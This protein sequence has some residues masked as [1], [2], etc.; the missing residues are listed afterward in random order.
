MATTL[1]LVVIGDR[2]PRWT[3]KVGR[4]WQRN[5]APDI[6]TAMLEHYE[7]DGWICFMGA[8]E[9]PK[10]V[11]SYL[12]DADP[13]PLQFV[14][15]SSGVR[16]AGP[17]DAGLP[18]T[19]WFEKMIGRWPGEIPYSPGS[20]FVIPAAYIRGRTREEIAEARSLRSTHSRGAE[21]MERLWRVWL[22]W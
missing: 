7:D 5:T 10:E 2:L 1:R 15:I 16:A 12:H 22:V 21:I 13:L 14:P 19:G 18:L 20:Q 3:K 9:P 17:N 8:E 4:R 6:F 11:L